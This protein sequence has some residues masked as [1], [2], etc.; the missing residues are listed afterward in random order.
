MRVLVIDSN[1]VYA[2]KVKTVLECAIHHITVDLASNVFI[3]RRRMRQNQYDL[4]IADIST[5][6]CQEMLLDE[7]KKISIPTITWTTVSSQ[8]KLEQLKTIGSRLMEKPNNDLELRERL[9]AAMADAIHP[10]NSI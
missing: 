4:I 3:T 6:V 1:I 5:V 2:Q 8:E 10:A 9:P 7:L